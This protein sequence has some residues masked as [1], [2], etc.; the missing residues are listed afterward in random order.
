MTY[1]LIS[2]VELSS[3]T[4]VVEFGDISDEGIMLECRVNAKSTRST[5]SDRIGFKTVD[6]TQNGWSGGMAAH[7]RT[8]WASGSMNYYWGGGTSMFSSTVYTNIAASGSSTNLTGQF[9]PVLMQYWN[10]NVDTQPT[11]AMLW[12][13]TLNDNSSNYSYNSLQHV[14]GNLL[15]YAG[16]SQFERLTKMSGLYIQCG[17]GDFVAGSTF[18]LYGYKAA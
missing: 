12:S 4:S 18:R 15:D 1:H 6:G 5:D 14:W 7:D 8:S 13:G 2:A 17:F 10:Y 9:S 11:S 3:T 16:G